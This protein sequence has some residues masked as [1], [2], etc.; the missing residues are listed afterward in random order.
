MA[1]CLRRAV[2]PE[3]VSVVALAGEPLSQSLVADIQRH[4]PAVT[5]FDLYGPDRDDGLRDICSADAGWSDDDWPS[6]GQCHGP[7]AGSRGG[8]P[9]PVGVAG[10]LFIG[11]AGV[12]RGYWGRDDLTAERFVVDPMPDASSGRMYRTGDRVRWRSDG[13]LEFI[14]RVDRQVKIRGLRIELGE[15]EAALLDQ[16]SVRE[17][18]ALRS[19]A[20][21]GVARLVACIAVAT[22][23]D[24]E[25][26]Y[27]QLE[28]RLPH[29]MVPTVVGSTAGAAATTERQGGLRNPARAC[30]ERQ[31]GE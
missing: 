12:A 22:P 24:D 25:A 27:A 15:I 18:V 1:E 5:I 23:V 14:G 19:E 4:S 13:T 31:R 21:D 3:G 20:A 29:Y 8:E 17:A 9:V 6:R 7:R 16:P 30:R 11:G 10:E 28:R 26:I 2:L